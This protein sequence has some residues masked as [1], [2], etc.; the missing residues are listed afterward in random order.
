MLVHIGMC[1]HVVTHIGMCHHV[2]QQLYEY[3][4]THIHE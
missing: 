1:Y 4:P 2:P 3:V